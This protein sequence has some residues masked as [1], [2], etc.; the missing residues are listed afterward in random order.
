[1]H[2]GESIFGYVSL[3]VVFLEEGESAE[4]GGFEL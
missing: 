3:E 2:G 1:M 4:C